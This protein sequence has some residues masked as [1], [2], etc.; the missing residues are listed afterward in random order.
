M[1]RRTSEPPPPRRYA[2]LG[3]V[4]EQYDVSE[5]TVRRWIASGRITGYRVGTLLI[6]LDLDEV[7]A[8]IVE[9]IP[10]AQVKP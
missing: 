3:A 8:N 9:V 5:R 1:A 10:A 6:K 4:A 2:S 7:E